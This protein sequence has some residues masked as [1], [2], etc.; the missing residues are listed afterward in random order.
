MQRHG[1]MDQFAN[2]STRHTGV[3]KTFVFLIYIILREQ[4]STDKIKR[5][6]RLCY[7]YFIC[8]VPSFA[9]HI[10]SHSLLST[11]KLH[12]QITECIDC[13]SS[14]IA[15]SRESGIREERRVCVQL[16]RERAHIHLKK[17]AELSIFQAKSLRFFGALIESEC[18]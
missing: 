16:Q 8:H 7:V 2:E 5:A 17:V 13:S 6:P 3:R 15:D 14:A 1:A 9:F 4:R 10:A 18:T 11:T 12:S